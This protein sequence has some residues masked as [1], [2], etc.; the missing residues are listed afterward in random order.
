MTATQSVVVGGMT[1][2]SCVTKVT[3]AVNLVPGVTGL[4]VDPDTATV[5]YTGTAA[6]AEVHSAIEQA[7]Y[8]I[9]SA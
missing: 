3:N 8:R 4:V 2:G 6:P 9:A 7:G 5:S 1:C